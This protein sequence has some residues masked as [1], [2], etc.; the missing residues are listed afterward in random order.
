ME[1]NVACDLLR[2]NFSAEDAA[3]LT[4]HPKRMTDTFTTHLM[5]PRKRAESAARMQAFNQGL[6]HLKDS[7]RHAQLLAQVSCPTE[8]GAS[9]K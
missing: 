8:W 4:A 7:G 6:K 1:R 3:R 2:R 9:S 5:L